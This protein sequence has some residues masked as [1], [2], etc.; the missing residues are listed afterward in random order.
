MTS[1][2]RTGR[3]VFAQR[4][5]F[6][7]THYQCFD[8]AR[9]IAESVV[10]ID[11]DVT[12]VIGIASGGI[13]PARLMADY[14]KVPLHTVTAKHN[15]SDAPFQQ[16]TG[17]VAVRL[18]NSLPGRLSGTV[19]LVDDIAGTGATFT[20]VSNALND[21]LDY[22]TEIMTAALFRNRGCTQTPDRWAWSVDDWVVFPW[23]TPHSGQTQPVPALKW[24]SAR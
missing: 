4:V 6:A 1:S 8:A 13:K 10:G 5:P 22:S 3:R 21:R 12:C 18:A 20:A 7:P 14:L 23:E 24:V 2:P 19:L 15:K 9:L 11:P 17:D 16:A